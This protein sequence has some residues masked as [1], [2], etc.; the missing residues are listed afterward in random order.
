MVPPNQSA[1]FDHRPEPLAFHVPVVA[2][3]PK[4]AVNTSAAIV[5]LRTGCQAPL[6]DVVRQTREQ[7]WGTG[8][9]AG[10]VTSKMRYRKPSSMLANNLP[11]QEKRRWVTEKTGIGNALLDGNLPS[12]DRRSLPM[13]PLA[14]SPLFLIALAQAL[15]LFAV[16]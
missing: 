6:L 4:A 7:G 11:C 5:A 10:G 12:T 15:L 1:E 3:L 2:A 16:Q 14:S 9:E 13:L 8:D